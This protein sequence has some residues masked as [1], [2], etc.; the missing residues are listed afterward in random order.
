MRNHQHDH[1]VAEEASASSM[2]VPRLALWQQWAESQLERR[3]A[4][5]SACQHPIAYR[6][7]K[8][9]P[10]DHSYV[11]GNTRALRKGDRFRWLTNHVDTWDCVMEVCFASSNLTASGGNG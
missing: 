8:R 11:L 9:P 10:K 2:R 7:T 5:D 6:R 4:Q 3:G 1:R